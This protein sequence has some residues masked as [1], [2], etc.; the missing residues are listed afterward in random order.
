MNDCQLGESFVARQKNT[1]WAP[2]SGLET[3]CLTLRGRVD[4]GP[5]GRGTPASYA[6]RRAGFCTMG[7][8]AERGSVFHSAPL[9]TAEIPRK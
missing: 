2:A 3:A 9:V 8:V 7:L 1:P 6:E 5:P 4:V